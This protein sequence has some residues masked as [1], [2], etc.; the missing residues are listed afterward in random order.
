MR[1]PTCIAGLMNAEEQLTVKRAV[2]LPCMSVEN[3]PLDVM[4]SPEWRP[5]GVARQRGVLM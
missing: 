1:K 3:F 2:I 4:S 5:A